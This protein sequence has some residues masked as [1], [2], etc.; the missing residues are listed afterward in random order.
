MEERAREARIGGMVTSMV[1]VRDASGVG[2]A[3]RLAVSLAS[4]AGL[5]ESLRGTL[6]L[7]ATEMATNLARHATDGMLLVRI[8][9]DAPASGSDGIE[10][11]AIDRGPGMHDVALAMRD[12][13]ST[14]GSRGAGL[15]AIMRQADTFDIHSVP[16]QGTVILAQFVTPAR[17]A[18]YRAGRTREGVVCRPAPGESLCG[19]IWGIRRDA[20]RTL[21]MVADGLGHGPGAAEAAASAHQAF[22]EHANARPAEIITAAHAALRP[23]RGAAMAVAELHHA[24]ETVRFAGV[25]NIGAMILSAE[26]TRSM[27]SHGGIVGHQ[28]RT[29]REFEYPWSPGARLLLH[30]DGIATRWRPEQYPGLAVRHPASIVAVLFRDYLRGRDDACLVAVARDTEE[31]R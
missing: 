6:A 30:S 28:M 18:S 4:E 14:A 15:G 16:E 11:L 21:V 29:V 23:T 10:L 12:G 31:P 22:H 13:H 19:D 20:E 27:A 9:G 2:E 8:L 3:R 7:V 25:G 1:H 17:R 24:R 26:G 5:D